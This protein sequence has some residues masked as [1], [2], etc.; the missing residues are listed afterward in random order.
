M[1][2]KKS[3]DADS[4]KDLGR[5]DNELGPKSNLSFGGFT[6]AA[7][8]PKSG[9]VKWQ[10]KTSKKNSNS[11]SESESES[12]TAESPKLISVSNLINILKG[13]ELQLLF[14]RYNRS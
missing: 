4:A 2:K 9:G 3:A 13:Q 11:E 14:F 6:A 8:S 10:T 1:D 12:S 7:L 5:T